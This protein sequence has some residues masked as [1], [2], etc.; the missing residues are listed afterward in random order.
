MMATAAFD[1]FIIAYFRLVA[2][3]LLIFTSFYV[4]NHVVMQFLWLRCM[5]KAA[6]KVLPTTQY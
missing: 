4:V 3:S 1:D 5:R 2:V 6:I